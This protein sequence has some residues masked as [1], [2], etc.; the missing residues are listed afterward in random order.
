MN[1]YRVRTY[2]V[3]CNELTISAPSEAEARDL[4]EEYEYVRDTPQ[5]GELERLRAYVVEKAW[6]AFVE[7]E[8]TCV[9]KLDADG[10]ELEYWEGDE[11]EDD[12][13]EE[14]EQA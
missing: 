10:N 12:R 8:R 2:E 4:A 11:D 14:E 6:H 5:P 7:V 9:Y 1:Q 13:P 3:Y